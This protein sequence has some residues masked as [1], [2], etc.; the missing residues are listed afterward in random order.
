MT[1]YDPKAASQRQALFCQKHNYPMYAPKSGLCWYCGK[2][3]YFGYE[4][5]NYSYSVQAAGEQLIT[6]C[7]YCHHSYCD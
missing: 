4:H 1:A 3:I 5:N 2:N 7:P 6:G